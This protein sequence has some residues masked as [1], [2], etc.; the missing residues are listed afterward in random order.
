MKPKP[1]VG[2]KLW[3]LTNGRTALFEE[4]IVIK[5]GRVYFSVQAIHGGWKVESQHYLKTWKENLVH[6]INRY[7]LFETEQEYHDQREQTNLLHQIQSKFRDWNYKP[8]LEQLRA[9]NEIIN[10]K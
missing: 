3:R 10:V 2:Q 4:V 5:V 1:T 8:T 7:S 6:G 9:I